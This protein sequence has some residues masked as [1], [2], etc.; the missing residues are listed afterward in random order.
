VSTTSASTPET[1]AASVIARRAADERTI[2]R[3]LV[4]ITYVAVAL[5][6]VGVVA[7]IAAGISPLDAPPTIDLSGIVSSA[8]ALDAAGLLW[9][10]LVVV[11]ATPIVRVVAAAIAYARGGE[12]RMVGISIAI[13]AI[14]AVGVATALASEVAG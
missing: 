2:G 13:L 12:R 4:G 1:P 9:L 3:L 10:G 6:L 14:I 8:L 11:I 7:M 5:L